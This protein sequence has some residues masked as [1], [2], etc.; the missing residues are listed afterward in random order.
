MNQLKQ[1]LSG[2][3]I[4]YT[5]SGIF[6]DA[7]YEVP[8]ISGFPLAVQAYGAS[9]VDLRMSGS[10]SQLDMANYNIDVRGKL[11]PSISVD[12]IGTMQ[13]DYFYGTS[14]VRVKSNLY[15]SSSVEANMKV[16][17]TKLVSLQV[18]LPQDRNDIFSAKSELLVLNN[19]ADIPQSGIQKRYTNSTCTWPFI[20]RAVGLKICGNYSLPDMSNSP[21]Q[22][23]SLLLCGPIDIDVH[24]DKADITAK[25]F[26][27]EYRLNVNETTKTTRGSFVFETPGS[28]IPRMLTANLTSDDESS[29]VSMAF[30]NGKTIHSAIGTY[31]VTDDEKL[32]EAHLNINGQKS[33]SL[34]V[35]IF[36]QN[37]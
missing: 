16:R 37:N 31:K 14:G 11:K 9:S 29:N 30:R 6:L 19:G 3:E 4:S 23:P 22:L 28:E 5:K 27:F 36:E 34:E 17:G 13:S 1:L 15:S 32:I 2:K 25:T 18:S 8:L 24:L 20:D 10:L 12:V 26:L 7:S 21:K 33:F 35:I